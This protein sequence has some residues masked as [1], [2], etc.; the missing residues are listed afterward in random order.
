MEIVA[1]ELENL[2]PTQFGG[3]TK[4][5]IRD[6]V[7]KLLELFAKGDDWKRRM[8]GTNEDITEKEQL[9]Q[10]LQDIYAEKDTP[11]QRRA[12]ATQAKRHLAAEARDDACLTLGEK[13][14]VCK[15]GHA[16][17]K[18]KRKLQGTEVVL[19]YLESKHKDDITMC[20]QE[21]EV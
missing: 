1:C 7:M 18:A 2:S 16:E 10:E 19:D 3:V 11:M 14:D 20:R 6:R 21:V 17:P 12:E 4:K 15:A 8:S 13:S 5:A 9:L